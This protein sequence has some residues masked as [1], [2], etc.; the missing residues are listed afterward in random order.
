LWDE[1]TAGHL[2]DEAC[3][4]FCEE[5]RY[6]TGALVD[7]VCL[8]PLAPFTRHYHLHAAVITVL[9]VKPSWKTTPLDKA[10]RS[11]ISG[12]WLTATGRPSA[13]L[14]DY[15]PDYLSLSHAPVEAGDS[16]RLTVVRRQVDNSLEA[17]EIPA[18]WHKHL[19]L[20][21]ADKALLKQDSEIGNAAKKRDFKQEW[22]EAIEVVKRDILKMRR[23]VVGFFYE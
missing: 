4:A 18:Q 12:G 7:D 1:A 17:L 8:I 5:T 13:Y 2:F 15:E 23:S 3:D 20:N 19:K 10:D 14:L 6:F 11:S 9:E 16:L 21:M 22:D